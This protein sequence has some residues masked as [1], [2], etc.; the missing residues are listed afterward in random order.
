MSS[1]RWCTWKMMKLKTMSW[2]KSMRSLLTSQRKRRSDGCIWGRTTRSVC[3]F[4]SG[5]CMSMSN[6]GCA[7]ATRAF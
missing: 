2:Q 3:R 7:A 6:D 4:T 5:S 1:L